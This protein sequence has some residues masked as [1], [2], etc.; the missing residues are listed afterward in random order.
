MVY[1]DFPFGDSRAF[2]FTARE[3]TETYTA[4]PPKIRVAGSFQ[5]RSAS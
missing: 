1:K 3:Q 5:T 4:T 2:T